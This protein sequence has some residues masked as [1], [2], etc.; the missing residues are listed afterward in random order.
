MPSCNRRFRTSDGFTYL[1]VLFAVSFIGIGLAAAGTVWSVSAQ[2]EKEMQLLFVG[3][4]FRNAIKSYYLHGPAGAR[5]YPQSLDDLVEDRRNGTLLRHIRKV[6]RDPV[7]NRQ[8][9]SLITTADG[10]ILGVSS[11]SS[12]Q[13]IKRANFSVDNQGLTDADCYCDWQFVY[14][15]QQN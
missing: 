9:W 5:Q 13:P 12:K 1:G 3:Q 14:L 4:R 8:D 2:R 7:T 10:A 11:S 6:Y 15:P